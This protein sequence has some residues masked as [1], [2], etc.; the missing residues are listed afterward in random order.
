MGLQ[1]KI[2]YKKGKDNIAADALSRVGHMMAIQVVSIVQ[3]TWVQELLNSYTTD[4][5]AH[6]LLQRLAITGPDTQ[7][8]SLDKGIIRYHGK[9]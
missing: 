9:V 7:G 5:Q 1:F 6:Q 4:S 3:P 2:I 8:Y